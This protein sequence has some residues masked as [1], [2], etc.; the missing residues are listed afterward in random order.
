MSIGSGQTVQ[1]EGM[2]ATGKRLGGAWSG[3]GTIDGGPLIGGLVEDVG[4]YFGW[5]V[6][7]GWLGGRCVV[8]LSFGGGCGHGDGAAEGWGGDGRD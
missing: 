8:D 4:P 1:L 6:A 3:R 7:G 5:G 2:G